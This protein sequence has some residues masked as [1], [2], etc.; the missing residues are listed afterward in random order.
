MRR[1]LAGI[2]TAVVGIAL[3]A[4]A[5][6]IVLAPSVGDAGEETWHRSDAGSCAIEGC[7]RESQICCSPDE[8]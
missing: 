1:I 4:G 8:D 5:G 3:A 7:D 2:R 6:A